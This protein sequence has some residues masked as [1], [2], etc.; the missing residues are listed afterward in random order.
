MASADT[1]GGAANCALSRP[2]RSQMTAHLLA[3]PVTTSGTGTKALRRKA[4]LHA[5]DNF[6]RLQ[7]E[8][9]GCITEEKLWNLLRFGCDDKASQALIALLY[10][11]LASIGHV[12]GTNKSTTH[13]SAG[14]SAMPITFESPRYAIDALDLFKLICAT[15]ETETGPN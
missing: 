4:A 1:Q 5:L 2:L 11:D 15:G 6:R 12:V 8:T 13:V 9:T 3:A 10:R 14:G 7:D